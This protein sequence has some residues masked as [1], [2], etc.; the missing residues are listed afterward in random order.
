MS[1]GGACPSQGNTFAMWNDSTRRRPRG[2]SSP[3]WCTG[4]PTARLWP[5][6]SSSTPSAGPGRSRSSGTA[7][8]RARAG[9]RYPWSCR[10]RGAWAAPRSPKGAASGSSA[11][12]TTTTLT[13]SAWQWS[14]WTWSPWITG[15]TGIGCAPIR[16]LAPVW[17]WRRASSTC[18]AW[19][20]PGSSRLRAAEA[21]RATST[22]SPSPWPLLRTTRCRVLM[23]LPR[24][25]MRRSWCC[26]RALE[27]CLEGRTPPRCS[28]RRHR[29]SLTL[30]WR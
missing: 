7:W 19:T 5:S 1:L 23:T 15:S 24:V 17:C 10:C 3:R 21:V 9:S 18:W 16:T 29:A 4:V 13:P 2:R 26:I 8:W 6:A 25:A 12:A 20:S 27:R 28:A 14:A 11:G 30:S 22:P